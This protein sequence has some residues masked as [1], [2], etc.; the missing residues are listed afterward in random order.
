MFWETVPCPLTMFG[1]THRVYLQASPELL[2]CPQKD[3]SL[4]F[5]YFQ[6]VSC[7][8]KVFLISLMGLVAMSTG[9]GNGEDAAVEDGNEGEQ[10]A[11]KQTA[12]KKRP[13]KKTVEQNLA[14]INRSESEMKCEV[15]R[16]G[17]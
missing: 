8:I 12:K 2:Y 7:V 11:A 5:T 13:P 16:V 3:A 6:Y 10:S 1:C 14:N 15:S 9:P 17:T 4:S